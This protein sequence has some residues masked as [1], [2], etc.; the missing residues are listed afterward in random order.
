MS[1]P[2]MKVIVDYNLCE[3]NA[4]CVKAAPEVFRVDESD[5]LHLLMAT[6]EGEELLDKVRAAV[7][8]CPRRAIA[9]EAGETPEG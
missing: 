5:N 4:Y 7:R 6:V 3:A 8:R 9:I 2:V 1:G